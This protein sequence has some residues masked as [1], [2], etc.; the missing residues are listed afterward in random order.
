LYYLLSLCITAHTLPFINSSLLLSFLPL[1]NYS[2]S[3]LYYT[4][5]PYTIF[6]ISMTVY[7]LL[8]LRTYCDVVAHCLYRPRTSCSIHSSKLDH[9]TVSITMNNV[10]GQFLSLAFNFLSFF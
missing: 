10:S 6:S 1:Y 7:S 3:S 5:L 8:Y 4:H 2:Y 9:A